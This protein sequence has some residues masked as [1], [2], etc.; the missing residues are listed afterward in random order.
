M[1]SVLMN[2]GLGLDPN[3]CDTI[4]V[5]LHD[6]ISNND[7]AYSGNVILNIDG[8]ASFPFPSTVANNSYFIVIRHR[9]SIETWSK[10]PVMLSGNTVVFDF[11]AP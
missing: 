11:T 10:E 5:E 2:T 3:E 4:L 9:N 1:Q 6:P 7:I 8:T